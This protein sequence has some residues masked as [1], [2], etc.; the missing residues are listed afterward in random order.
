MSGSAH[1]QEC[2]ELAQREDVSVVINS[3][4]EATK[5]KFKLI[6][7]IGLRPAVGD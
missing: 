2:V 3:K 7:D 5:A 6:P 4:Y 1:C